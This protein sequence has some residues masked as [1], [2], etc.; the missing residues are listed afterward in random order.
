MTVASL[1]VD[2]AQYLRRPDLGR[3][4]ADL[5]GLVRTDADLAIVLADG[6]SSRALAD[7]GA[8]L[9]A[10]INDFARRRRRRPAGHRD[11]GACGLSATM[12][13][14]PWANRPCWC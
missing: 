8:P 11:A 13:R 10:A 2:R 1:A 4:P 5:S 3:Q 6:L 9:L 14:M 12:S 7:H